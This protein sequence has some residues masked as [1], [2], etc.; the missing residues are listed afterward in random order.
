MTISE[1]KEHILIVAGIY[2]II[3][4]V[5]PL[6][7]SMLTTLFLF[8]FLGVAMMILLNKTP[9]IITLIPVKAP[10]ITI[11]LTNLGIPACMDVLFFLGFIV[12]AQFLSPAAL[13]NYKILSGFAV[14]STFAVAI[15]LIIYEIC[16]YIKN[17][18]KG[19]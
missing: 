9:N 6:E 14:F 8:V 19:E 3:A 12:M 5:L 15:L 18:G 11:I 16:K 13:E 1:K 7:M 2:G 4:E 10:I 17:A